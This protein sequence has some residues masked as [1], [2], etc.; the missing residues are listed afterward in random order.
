MTVTPVS[1]SQLMG[2]LFLS[3]SSVATQSSTGWVLHQRSVSHGSGGRQSQ[4]KGPADSVPGEGPSWLADSLLAV[5]SCDEREFWCLLVRVLIL[6]WSPIHI[7]PPHLVTFQRPRL[8][9]HRT[10]GSAFTPEFWEDANIRSV[11]PLVLVCSGCH[12]TVPQTQWCT[13]QTFLSHSPGGWTPETKES[14]GLVP[15][16]PLSAACGRCLLPMSSTG[17]P[18]VLVCVLVSPPCEDTYPIGSGPSLTVS[19]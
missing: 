15:P 8:L 18:P 16:R 3:V 10:G 19:F 12:N 1:V 9:Y 4:T 5:S 13:Q 17:L 14:A 11:T 6:S 2:K 7:R